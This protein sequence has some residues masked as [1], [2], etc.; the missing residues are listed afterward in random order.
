MVKGAQAQQ[1]I[2]ESRPFDRLRGKMLYP[3]RVD[4]PA[5]LE[6]DIRRR[7]ERSI[8]QSVPARWAR[9][10]IRQPWSMHGCACEALTRYAWLMRQSCQP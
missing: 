1:R 9:I 4:D 3:T 6:R 8:T 7:A 2:I 10:A 5:D